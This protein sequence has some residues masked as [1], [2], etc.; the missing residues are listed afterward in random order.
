MVVV[1]KFRLLPTEPWNSSRTVVRFVLPLDVDPYGSMS[2]LCNAVK[3]E[4]GVNFQI[5]RDARSPVNDTAPKESTPL[6]YFC[7]RKEDSYSRMQIFVR[8]LTE[9]TMTLEPHPWDTIYNLM[10]EIEDLAGI[11]LV[12]QRLVFEGRQLGKGQLLSFA[13][14]LRLRFP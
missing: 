4:T 3:A 13:L 6:F 7:N 2:T 10:C 1:H 8:G 14:R 5:L 11:P 12:Q 9:K